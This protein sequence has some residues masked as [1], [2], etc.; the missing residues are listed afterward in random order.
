MKQSYL[1]YNA[2]LFA[3]LFSFQLTFGQRLGLPGAEKIGLW[4]LSRAGWICPLINVLYPIDFWISVSGTNDQENYGY[5]LA[6]NLR[7]AGMSEA[8][9]TGLHQTWMQWHR[10]NYETMANWLREKKIVE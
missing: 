4:G 5:L 9:V 10:R 7:I 6:S 2:F 8:E 3:F 1:H